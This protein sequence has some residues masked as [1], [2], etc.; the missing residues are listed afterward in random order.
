MANDIIAC[1]ICGYSDYLFNGFNV[2]AVG[3]HGEATLE[4]KRCGAWL[5]FD[6]K[7]YLDTETLT[8]DID[9]SD[10]EEN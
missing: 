1:G 8:E 4:C 6:W 5:E 7:D 2:T 9:E 3:K 10:W